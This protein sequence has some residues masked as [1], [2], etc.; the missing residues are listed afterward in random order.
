MGQCP[1]CGSRT[2]RPVAPKG[3]RMAFAKDRKCAQCGTVWRVACPMW[4][5]WL[6]VFVGLGLLAVGGWLGLD[7]LRE[8]GLKQ[9]EAIW[10]VISTGC[11]ALGYG[12]AVVTGRAGRLEIIP[13]SREEEGGE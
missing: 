12:F 5:G 6:S 3:V 1:S 7:L 4:A 10:L 2:H 8:E 13:P 11:V 9:T